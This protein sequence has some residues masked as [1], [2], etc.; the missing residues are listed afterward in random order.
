MVEY[1]NI[2]LLWS[3]ILTKRT[4]INLLQ[5]WNKEF[6]TELGPAQP[7]LAFI[8]PNKSIFNIHSILHSQIICK[9]LYLL[10]SKSNFKLLC[11][12]V[13]SSHLKL[14]CWKSQKLP[15]Q[16][17]PNLLNLQISWFIANISTSEISSFT[18][19]WNRLRDLI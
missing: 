9:P 13:P 5:F 16:H 7:R 6:V 18:F 12:K 2:I 19:L 1:I 3:I 11:F 4:I 15:F 8:L 14:M 17:F 10:H